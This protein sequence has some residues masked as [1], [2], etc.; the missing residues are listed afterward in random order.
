[1][2]VACVFASL[3][4]VACS[5]GPEGDSNGIWRSLTT[6]AGGSISADSG[7]HGAC[8]PGQDETCGTAANNDDIL[9]FCRPD[10]SCACFTSVDPATGK[11]M[12]P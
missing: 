4:L 10:A 12:R 11:C 5:F 3:Y 9:G 6:D 2:R 8:V 1:M 7:V